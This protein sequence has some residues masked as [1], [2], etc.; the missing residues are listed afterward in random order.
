MKLI[1]FVLIMVLL[2]PK[3]AFSKDPF[4]EHLWESNNAYQAGQYLE[5]KVALMKATS[6]LNFMLSKALE[7]GGITLEKFRSVFD[8]LTDVQF[9]QLREELKDKKVT[10]SGYLD[11]V[12]EKWFGG[13]EIQIDMDP[14]ETF[15][16]VYDVSL[17]VSSDM[18]D[19]VSTLTK[20]KQVKFEGKIKSIQKVLGKLVVN[21]RDVTFL[22]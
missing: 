17:T 3:V 9:N 2:F 12:K 5:T 19:F 1:V 7:R 6:A 16:S 10:W 11:D 15:L 14:P 8:E 22:D 13:F 18:K 20:D 4:L 21:I